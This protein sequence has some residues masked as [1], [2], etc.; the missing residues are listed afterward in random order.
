MLFVET[1]DDVKKLIKVMETGSCFMQLYWRSKKHPVKNNPLLIAIK[2]IETNQTYVISFSHPDCLTINIS[3]LNLIANTN[4]KKFLNDHKNFLYIVKLKNCID[5]SLHEYFESLGSFDNKEPRTDD[6]RSIPIMNILKHFKSAFDFFSKNFEC[7]CKNFISYENQ[8]SKNLARLE[9][10][11][12]YVQ[13]FNIGDSSLVDEENLV[14]SQYNMKTPTGRPSNRFGGVNFAALNKKQGERNCFVSRYGSDGAIVMMDYES[15]HLRL[16]GNYI[17]F[18][19][20]TE[21]LHT[22]LG[23][24]YHGKEVLTEEE[25]DLSKKITFNLIYGGI[26]NDIKD[27]VPFMK[28][29]DEYVQSTYKVYCNKKYV[30]SWFFHRRINER[31]FGNN[32]NPYKLFNYLLQ[33]AETERNS[34]IMSKIFDFI[35]NK[36]SKFILYT[37]DAFLFDMHKTE[38]ADVKHLTQIMNEDNKYP[39]RTYVG[40]SYGDIK[41][42]VF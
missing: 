21:S 33:S 9:S 30:E 27:N 28:S 12:I 14:Y 10:S 32:V 17:N 26:S 35:E 22:Y 1:S 29:I 41:E 2:H 11:G 20:P 15:Y 5:I 39:V 24:L 34:M 7:V 31:I 25:Y 37:Y 3:V 36:K 6:L 4:C 42:L 40:K 19:L 23:K 13:N 18:N 38:F 8:L 16:V